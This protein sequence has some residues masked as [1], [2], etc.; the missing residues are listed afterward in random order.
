VPL[1]PI[2][3]EPSGLTAGQSFTLDFILGQEMN[4]SFDFY[5]LADTPYGS[6]TIFPNGPVVKGIR[7][8]Y[9]N[10]PWYPAPFAMTIRPAAIIP[11]SMSGSVVTLYAA[12]VQA[13]MRPPVRSLA[14]V[15]PDSPYLIL[16]SKKAVAV[17]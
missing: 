4:R 16:L 9:T 13:G 15:E 3:I 2:S 7:P 10:I 17:N 12:T 6:Y 5:I 14:E 1:P 8:I 11:C